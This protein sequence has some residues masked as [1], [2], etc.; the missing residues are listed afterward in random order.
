MRKGYTKEELDRMVTSGMRIQHE[1][2][3]K[4]LAGLLARWLIGGDDHLRGDADLA[5]HTLSE[6]ERQGLAPATIPDEVTRG[7]DMV[8]AQMV[9]TAL[10]THLEDERREAATLEDLI[11]WATHSSGH[12]KAI[13]AGLADLRSARDDGIELPGHNVKRD[14]TYTLPLPPPGQFWQ[15]VRWRGESDG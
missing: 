4:A 8:P 12:H 7:W 9:R 5:Q 10:A 6:L 1:H 3:R 2:D 13:Y 11:D 14:Y 15:S